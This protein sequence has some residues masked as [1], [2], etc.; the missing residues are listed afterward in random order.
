MDITGANGQLVPVRFRLVVF[1]RTQIRHRAVPRPDREQISGARRQRIRHLVAVRVIGDSRAQRHRSVPPGLVLPKH[2]RIGRLVKLRRRVHDLDGHRGRSRSVPAVGDL[3]ADRDAP[4]IG[5]S[6]PVRLRLVGRSRDIAPRRTPGIRQRI[7]VGVRSLRGQTYLS[8]RSDPAR[9]ARSGH[10]RRA[11]RWIVAVTSAAKVTASAAIAATTTAS[12]ITAATIFTAAASSD[13]VATTSAAA[14]DSA[15]FVTPTAATA[16]G[17]ELPGAQCSHPGGVPESELET[18]ETGVGP[19]QI[20][21]FGVVCAGRSPAPADRRA[22][23]P[24]SLRRAGEPAILYCG[25]LGGGR[26]EFKADRR[27]HG[28][29]G[30]RVDR[31]AAR[32]GG[33]YA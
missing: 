10:R 30:D 16:A 6:P 9:D 4:G 8:A 21:E 14:F 27:S 15:V 22:P 13:V 31:G 26:R 12:A 7:A 23:P 17:V 28:G 24:F 5:R 25:L 18:G 1:A 11:V 33:V 20:G 19:P 3:H 29:G 2:E 32:G